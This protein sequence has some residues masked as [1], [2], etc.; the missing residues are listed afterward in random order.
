MKCRIRIALTFD[1][2]YYAHFYLAKLL[3]KFGIKATFFIITGLKKWQNIPLIPLP[4]LK[5][6]IK[7]GHEIASHTHLHND[8]TSCDLS[9]IENELKT[10]KEFLEKITGSKVTGFAYPYGKYNNLVKKL[11]AKYYEYART[12]DEMKIDNYEFDRY[13]I[14]VFHLSPNDILK[15]L[16]KALSTSPKNIVIVIHYMRPISLLLYLTFLKLFLFGKFVTL[17]EMVNNSLQNF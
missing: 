16:K 14:K 2:G 7:E 5:Q 6:M 9:T 1:D 17:K 8:L 10:S 4:L 15:I 13:E 11:V 3:N 12:I